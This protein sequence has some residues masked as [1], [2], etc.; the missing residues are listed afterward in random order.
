MP[1]MAFTALTRA[2]VERSLRDHVHLLALQGGDLLAGIRR[3]T[4]DDGV[5]VGGVA[6]YL[7]LG[8]RVRS[9]PLL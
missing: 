3:D 5:D 6:Q 1:G 7:S 2:G 4:E 9:T 8:T